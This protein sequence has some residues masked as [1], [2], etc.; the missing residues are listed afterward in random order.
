VPVSTILN[1][2]GRDRWLTVTQIGLQQ[3]DRPHPWTDAEVMEL[4][5]RQTGVPD[6]EVMLLNRS[7]WRVSR[8]VAAGFRKG[9]CCWWGMP[10]TASRP[11]AASA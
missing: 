7:V 8:Q 10:R 9:R 5:R 3:D 6:L 4:I 11:P 2:N 1:T